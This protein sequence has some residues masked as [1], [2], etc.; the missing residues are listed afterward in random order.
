[1]D[2]KE[3]LPYAEAWQVDADVKDTVG[4]DVLCALTTEIKE[5]RRELYKRGVQHIKEK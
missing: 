2:I 5:L 3:A 1:M 4:G